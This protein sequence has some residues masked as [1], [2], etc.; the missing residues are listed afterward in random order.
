[1]AYEDFQGDVEVQ[2]DHTDVAGHSENRTPPIAHATN[3][4]HMLPLIFILF[5]QFK[6]SSTA[7]N[8]AAPWVD[9]ILAVLAQQGI[10]MT[11]IKMI[12]TY[13]TYIAGIGDINKL[14]MGVR[15]PISRAQ[16]KK[17]ATWASLVAAVTEFII[18]TKEG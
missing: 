4:K 3:D 17:L 12:N 13:A 11:E 16:L 8:I 5:D 6:S 14:P 15:L 7:Q 18:K 10:G 2:Q 1:L 9:K